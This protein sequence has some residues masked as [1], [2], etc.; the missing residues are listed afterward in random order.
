MEYDVV[1]VGAGPAGLGAAIRVKQLAAESGKDLSVC[2]VEKGSEVG[3]HILSGNVFETK[4]LDELIPDWKEKGAPLNTL[5]EKDV[6]VFMTGDKGGIEIPNWALP[7]TLDNHGNYIISLGELCRW[8]AEQAEE[9]GVEIYPGF[10]ADE[11][12]YNETGAVMGIATKDVGIGK[13]GEAKDTYARGMEL[14]GRQTLFAEGCR[15]SCSEEVIS[16]FSLRE[17][18]DMQTY[19]IGLKEVW[20]IPDANFE[21]G[22]IQHSIGWPLTSDVYGGTFLYHMAPNKVM[23]GM[24]VGL[25]YK[26]PYLSP[27]QEFQ[28]WKTHPYISKHL[29]GGTCISYGARAL[30][31][32]GLQAI[33]KLTFPGGALVG[34]SAGFVNVPKIKGSHT[35]MK[36]GMLAGESL[37]ASLT[38][39]SEESVALGSELATFEAVE[40]TGYQTAIEGSWV[41]KELTEVRNVHPAFHRGLYAGLIYS[42][43]SLKIFGG[44]EPWTLRNSSKGDHTTT[45]KAADHKE[46]DYP[47]PDGVLTFDILSNL[48]R[49]GVYHEGDQPAHLTIK[50]ELADWPVSKSF[51]EYAGPEARFCP[52]KVYEYVTDEDGKPNLVI[53]A[54]NCVH[55]KTCDIK[56]PGNY[57]KWT[58]PE[59]SGG[60]QYTGM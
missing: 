26:N 2:V 7:K 29:E 6:F 30:N 33:P 54:Q 50:P 11:V 53:N 43:L 16:K 44:K 18:K 37:F 24:V 9:L 52:A 42:G 38:G 59:G 60:P 47:K 14:R 1:I 12:I 22:Y 35:A 39:Q 57:I 25:D 4:A 21:S 51:Q 28:R 48:Q 36:S 55:C 17:G 56:T 19:G 45:G 49:S 3:L 10:A 8:L 46:I 15:G 41:W 58:V 13:N 27:Y 20:E 5:A 31:E 32:G 40:A 23:L 34:C